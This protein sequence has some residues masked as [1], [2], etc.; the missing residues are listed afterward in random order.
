MQDHGGTCIRHGPGAHHE[1]LNGTGYPVHKTAADIPYEVRIITILD[2]FDSLVADDRPYKRAVPVDRA[3]SILRGMAGEEG[4]LDPA[5][6]ELFTKSRCW[7]RL[8]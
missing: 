5:L 2:I 7:E 1:Y 8:A 6:T 4:K 3:L